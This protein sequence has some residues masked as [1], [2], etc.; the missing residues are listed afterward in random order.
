ML[1]LAHYCHCFIVLEDQIDN[2]DGRAAVTT[3]KAVTVS[4]SSGLIVISNS[5]PPY[6]QYSSP[7]QTIVL[8]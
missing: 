7:D 5:S 1:F 3:R 4:S 2:F 6:S 8:P